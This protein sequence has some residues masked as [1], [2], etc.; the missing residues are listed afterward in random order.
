MPK[1]RFEQPKKRKKKKGGKIALVILCVVLALV[2]AL[3]LGIYAYYRSMLNRITYVQ[4]PT[5]VV[6]PT[7][8]T[9]PPVPTTVGENTESTT[10]PTEPTEQRPMQASDIINILVAGNQSRPG[11]EQMMADTM[12]LVTLNTYTKTVTLT[13]L[14][15]DTYLS[16]PAYKA[17][18]HTAEPGR[19]KL[20]MVYNLGYVW[21]DISTAMDYLNLTLEQNFGI[22][23]DYN[24]DIGFDGFAAVVD[25]LGGIKID[26]TQAEAD[27][28]NL[29][30]Y[31]WAVPTPV[32]EG[33]N[34]LCGSAALAYARMRHAAGD[35][36]SDIKRTSR[37]RKVLEIMLNEIRNA[38]LMDLQ[39]IA[40][41][42][43]PLITTNMSPD[44]ITDLMIKVVPMLPELTVENGVCPHEYWGDVRDIFGTG[45]PLSILEFNSQNEKAYMR[46]ITEGEGLE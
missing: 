33:E 7:V 45:V 4:M 43:L 8:E 27:Y 6:L 39:Q 18:K 31:E 41:K 2:L 5:R 19:T 17:P 32:H 12:I 29:P 23:V 1:G 15:R 30:K 25:Q 9:E 3:I 28:L 38:S 26:L 44:V 11:E 21:G 24:V 36:D 16:T 35:N 14:L 37:Q 40:N 46:R 42:V 10:A 13:S 22:E 20:N 34:L